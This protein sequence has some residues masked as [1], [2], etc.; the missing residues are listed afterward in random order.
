LEVAET[1]RSHGDDDEPD[2]VPGIVVV[3]EAAIVV[4][5]VKRVI[6]VGDFAYP[7]AEAKTYD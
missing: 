3:L 5:R 4:V 6:I 7:H 1:Y 2:A